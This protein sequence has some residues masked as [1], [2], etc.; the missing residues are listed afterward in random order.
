MSCAAAIEPG[1]APGGETDLTYVREKL[2]RLTLTMS[3][4]EVASLVAHELSQPLG[5]MQLHAT[6]CSRW[7]AQTPPNLEEAQAAAERTLRDGGRVRQ[8][9]QSL[10]SLL[11]ACEPEMTAVDLNEQVRTALHMLCESGRA[12]ELE[13]QFDLQALPVVECDPL[14]V[15][16]VLLCLLLNAVEAMAETPSPHVLVIASRHDPAEGAVVAISDR[17]IGIDADDQESLFT[18]L[19]TT[20]AGGL[21]LSLA[22][23]RRIVEAHGGRIWADSNRDRGATFSFSLPAHAG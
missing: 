18:P 11:P 12:R 22:I 6:A 7:L 13:V 9:M 2:L 17:G 21:G 20:K 4:T 1:R 8:A 5:A 23:S 19:F 15:T 14:Q 16:H 3:V 10:R